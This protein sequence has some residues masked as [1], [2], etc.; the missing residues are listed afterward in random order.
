MC[1]RLQYDCIKCGY[2]LGPFAMNNEQE[3]KP[4]SCP[5]CSSKGPFNVRMTDCVHTQLGTLWSANLCNL[6]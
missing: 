6:G 4:S 3:V 1:V 2:V 5:S